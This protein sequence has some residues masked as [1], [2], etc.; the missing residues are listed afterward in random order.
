MSMTVTMAARKSVRFFH[1]L[2]E[3]FAQAQAM[4]FSDGLM[5]YELVQA[6]AGHWGTE[7]SD[8]A[9][10][11]LPYHDFFGEHWEWLKSRFSDLN[12][13]DDI[14]GKAPVIL[15]ELKQM[16]KSSARAQID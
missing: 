3:Y 1:Q 2:G 9:A 14:E 7:L 12:S 4:G 11:S 13:R 8:V 5:L 16:V 6:A 10:S 15:S